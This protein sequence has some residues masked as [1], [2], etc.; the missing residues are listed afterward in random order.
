MPRCDVRSRC[1]IRVASYD[2]KAG[3]AVLGSDA[4]PSGDDAHVVDLVYL[5][6]GSVMARASTEGR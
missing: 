1:K 3:A 4:Q 5:S 2:G 6:R